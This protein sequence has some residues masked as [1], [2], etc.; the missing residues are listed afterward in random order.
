MQIQIQLSAD[1]LRLPIAC[2]Y[3]V[4]GMIYH[5]LASSP[6]YQRFLHDRGYT[7]DGKQFKC[8]TFGRLGGQYQ[9]ADGRILFFNGCT[10]EIRSCD[11][12]LIQLLLFGFAEGSKHRLGSNQVTA[13]SC[14]LEDRHIISNSVD[15]FM[16]S[17]LTVYQTAE[18]GYT[19]YAAPNEPRFY[20]WVQNNAMQKWNSLMQYPLSGGLSIEPLAVVLRDKVVTTY[21]GTYI[22]GWMGTYRL[23]GPQQMLDLLYQI[24][25]GAKN[26]QGFGMFEVL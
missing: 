1:E 19:D 5:A 13:S 7:A 21:K 3:M 17:P 12:Y 15:I 20:E 23:S 6:H 4:Q 14:Y 22:I 16:L 26:S 10:L 2:Q 8:F 11:P 24:G 9:I 25:L 18:S